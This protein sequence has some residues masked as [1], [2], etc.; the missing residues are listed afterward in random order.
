MRARDVQKSRSKCEQY[1]FVAVITTAETCSGEA[2]G[3][4]ASA[5]FRRM[6]ADTDVKEAVHEKQFLFSARNRMEV[7]CISIVYNSTIS[8]Q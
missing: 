5:L 4:K 8:S 3:R 7:I 1:R 2:A 6:N